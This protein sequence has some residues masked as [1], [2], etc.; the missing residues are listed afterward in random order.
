MGA[1][2]QTGSLVLIDNVIA[3]RR[4]ERTHK[5]AAAEGGCSKGLTKNLQGGISEF[6]YVR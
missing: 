5:Q 2:N 6:D 1:D 4:T 3:D